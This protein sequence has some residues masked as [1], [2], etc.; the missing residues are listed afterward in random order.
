MENLAREQEVR[1]IQGDTSGGRRRD[2][3]MGHSSSDLG[4][5]FSSGSGS[6]SSR[7]DRLHLEKSLSL[8]DNVFQGENKQ[9]FTLLISFTLQI[10][11]HCKRYFHIVIKFL[12]QGNNGLPLTG[13]ESMQL[14]ILKLFVSQITRCVFIFIFMST[15]E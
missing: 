14:A 13:F 4:E 2:S 15:S 10:A 9:V 5:S 3:G 11:G 7:M 1:M 8:E 6:M 12:P